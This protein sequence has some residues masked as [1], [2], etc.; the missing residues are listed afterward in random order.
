TCA[1][2]G[3]AGLPFATALIR[4]PSTSTRSPSRNAL[5]LPSNSRRFV[6]RI[7]RGAP[8]VGTDCAP[9]SRG[10]PSDPIEAAMPAT[11]P[12]R[13]RSAPILR[14]K[15]RI[16]CLWQ[17]HPTWLVRSAVSPDVH[18]NMASDLQRWRQR[19]C[20]VAYSAI[21]FAG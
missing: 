14:D 6:N 13:E 20:Y 12:R 2:S 7:G 8:D 9:A 19:S 5:A 21:H 1:P 18:E 16:S 17:R 3:G 4:L 10:R 11:K 15:D